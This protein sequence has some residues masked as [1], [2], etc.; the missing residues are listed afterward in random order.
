MW[1]RVWLIFLWVLMSGVV[2][3]GLYFFLLPIWGR[4]SVRS[5]AWRRK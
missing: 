5:T 4:K 2:L 1:S 3:E